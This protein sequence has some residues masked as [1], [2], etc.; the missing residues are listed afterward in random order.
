MNNTLQRLDLNSA[1]FHLLLVIV[2]HPVDLLFATD[3]SIGSDGARAIAEALKGAKLLQYLALNCAPLSRSI[4][5]HS[6]GGTS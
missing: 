2:V 5:I 6:N 1:P 3:N 4:S